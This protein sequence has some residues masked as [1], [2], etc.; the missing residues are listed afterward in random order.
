MKIPS[1]SSQSGFTLLEVIIA[2]SIFAVISVMSYQGI[3]TLIT[4]EQKSR[5]ALTDLT[6]L[7]RALMIWERDL[8]QAAPRSITND[9]GTTQPSMQTGEGMLLELSANNYYDWSGK[10]GH[11][12]QRIRY[13]F[14]EGKL[15]REV[16]A[17]P[18]YMQTTQP[19][20]LI[21]LENL[22]NASVEIVKPEANQNETS[23]ENT[24]ILATSNAVSLIIEHRQFG[25]IT[26][27]V[28]PYPL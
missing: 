21:L 15:I 14:S 16:W 3:N 11:T 9:Y 20:A 1:K 5:H 8:R 7:Q 23:S 17:Y 12:I 27:T 19:Q 10:S 18:D 22:I 26:R 25:T 24:G 2:L 13:R 28:L 6:E 4:T